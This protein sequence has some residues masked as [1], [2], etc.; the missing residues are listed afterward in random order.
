V[1]LCTVQEL[2]D[3]M[4]SQLLILTPGQAPQVEARMSS[5]VAAATEEAAQQEQQQ[6][7]DMPELLDVPMSP[8]AAAAAAAA[9]ATAEGQDGAAALTAAESAL[10]HVMRLQDNLSST[11]SSLGRVSANLQ[12]IEVGTGGGGGGASACRQE[13]GGTAA[14]SEQDVSG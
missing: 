5:V 9:E 13:E 1:L 14:S 6:Y 8:R 7:D 4:L 10:G 2:L 3:I 11:R 12:A